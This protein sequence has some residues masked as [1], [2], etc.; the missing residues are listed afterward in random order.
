MKSL[1]V[2]GRI[3]ENFIPPPPPPPSTGIE[4][5]GENE[6]IVCIKCYSP[7]Y[8]YEKFSGTW[9]D[10]S[11]KILL[12]LPVLIWKTYLKSVDSS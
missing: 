1:N 3:A 4:S 2:S 10:S 11:K 6:W 5:L 8:W 12:Y 7:Q 9:V